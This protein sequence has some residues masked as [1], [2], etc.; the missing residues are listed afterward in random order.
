MT[1]IR[2][3]VDAFKGVCGGESSRSRSWHAWR[4]GIERTW[5]IQG[6]ETTSGGVEK[7]EGKKGE[8]KTQAEENK[9]QI[10]KDLVCNVKEFGLYHT[11]GGGGLCKILCTGVK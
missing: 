11:S 4:P 1:Q 8:D 2:G 7:V 10:I 3:S 5:S 6:I 9:C